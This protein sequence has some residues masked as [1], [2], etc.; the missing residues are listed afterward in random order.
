M[1][2]A[3]PRTPEAERINELLTTAWF[4]RTGTL[5]QKI[6]DLRRYTLED[7]L[8]AS[9][10]IAASPKRRI[11]GGYS[12]TCTVDRNTIPEL[13]AW[14]IAANELDAIVSRSTTKQP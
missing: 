4:I 8:Q 2:A 9:A 11:P 1:S 6:P 3:P 5:D 10:A 14:A 13:Y 7:C 12:Y